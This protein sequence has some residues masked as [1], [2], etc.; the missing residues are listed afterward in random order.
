MGRVHLSPWTTYGEGR[1]FNLCD[2]AE[3][4]VLQKS[5]ISH[6]DVLFGKLYAGSVAA[7]AVSTFSFA[8]CKWIFFF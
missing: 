2:E 5:A 3:D 6:C 4:E 1:L 7:V 8:R